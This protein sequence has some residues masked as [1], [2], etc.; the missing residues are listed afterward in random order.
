MIDGPPGRR[1]DERV[2]RRD[3]GRLRE[4]EAHEPPADP[5]IVEHLVPVAKLE[6]FKREP[7]GLATVHA[8]CGDER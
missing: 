7:T 2:A 5:A 6:A 3:H 1:Q 4:L 8:E